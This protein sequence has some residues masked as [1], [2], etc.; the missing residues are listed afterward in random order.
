MIFADDIVICS[1]NKEQIEESQEVETCNGGKR[2]E[3][4]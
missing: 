4:L 2:N 3:T 1:E